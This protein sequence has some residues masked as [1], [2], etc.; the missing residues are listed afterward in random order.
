MQFGLGRKK[1]FTIGIL[2][3]F[4]WYLDLISGYYYELLP[5]PHNFEIL[6]KPKTNFC[7]K[8]TL[9]ITMV[10]IAPSQFNTRSLIRNTWGNTTRFSNTRVIFLVG[11]S[12]NETINQ[13]LVI[14][15]DYFKDIL[16]EDFLDSYNNLTKK[17]IMGLKWVNENCKSIKFVMKIDDDIFVNTEALI[18]FLENLKN[19]NQNT[20]TQIGYCYS[21]IKVIRN[22]FS[23]FYVPYLDYPNEYF[24]DFCVGSVYLLSGD[25]IYLLYKESL[26]FY[27]PIPQQL[28]DVYI[29]MLFNRFKFRYNRINIRQN[30]SKLNQVKSRNF[31][32]YDVI[33]PKN[34]DLYLFVTMDST[35]SDYE[36]AWDIINTK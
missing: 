1:L 25:L 14:E 33:T 28:E 19:P 30:F 18:K 10:T 26:R 8:D 9:L 4:V 6:L 7:D 34:K 23:K 22:K 27:P 2:F 3:S 12:R 31:N 24:P 36:I 16:Q 11:R 5:F 21:N 20:K 32:V 17:V 15:S 13:K 29:G 35:R